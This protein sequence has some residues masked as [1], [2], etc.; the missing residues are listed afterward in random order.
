MTELEMRDD[1]EAWIGQRYDL[2]RVAENNPHSEY[3]L[4]GIDRAW[5]AWQAATARAEKRIKNYFDLADKLGADD[6]TA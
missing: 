6:G 1:F 5:Q 4:V 2:S 3:A